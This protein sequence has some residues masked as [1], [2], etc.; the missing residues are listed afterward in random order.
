M[1]QKILVFILTSLSLSISILSAEE[2]VNFQGD[3]D[4]LKQ[5]FKLDM[6]F[7]EKSQ[8]KTNLNLEDDRFYLDAKIDHLKF[9]KH[10]FLTEFISQGRIISK[11]GSK[12]L[13]CSAESKYSLL[14]Y[15]PF[16]DITTDFMINRD[17]LIISTLRWGK[18]NIIGDISLTEPYE[19]N[20][21]AEIKD[22]DINELVAMLGVNL[23]DFTMSGLVEGFLRFKGPKS[24][25]KITG[26]LKASDGNIA[27]LFYREIL[28]KVDGVYPVI[29]L[30]D[31]EVLE[32]D[33]V[34]YAFE[35]RVNLTEINNLYSR[36]HNFTFF[37]VTTADGYNLHK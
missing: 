33:G 36:E 29:Y 10:D 23:E 37:P 32:E 6:V 9:S 25:V 3:L 5:V 22:A 26:Q 11:D 15:K 7:K 2:V 30:F 24:N 14:D 27:D 19:I 17:S 34:V 12:F 28:V 35:G 1:K 4:F 31:T 8:V 21:Y 13:K 16:K 20:L 18:N